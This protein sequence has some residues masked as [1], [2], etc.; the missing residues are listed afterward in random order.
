MKNC[1]NL[2]FWIYDFLDGS[3]GHQANG[4]HSNGVAGEDDPEKEIPLLE[5]LDIDLEMVKSNLKAVILF[6]QFRH[7]F[8][9]DPD[10]TGPLIV[11]FSLA[12]SLMLVK[13]QK[14]MKK[15]QISKNSFFD[16]FRVRRSP[17]ATFMG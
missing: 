3:Y 11:G 2:N 9:E 17:L 12:L 6:K 16:F 7:E 14:K 10:M 5:D 1:Q 8:T 15:L 13:S 4:A